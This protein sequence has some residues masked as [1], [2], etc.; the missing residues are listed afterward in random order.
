[1]RA[2]WWPLA[3]ALKALIS[4]SRRSAR[5]ASASA[6]VNR[7]SLI[8]GPLDQDGAGVEQ[9]EALTLRVL[10]GLGPGLGDDHGDVAAGRGRVGQPGGQQRG[11]HAPAPVRGHG[12]RAGELRD[13]LGYPHGGPADDDPVAQRGVADAAGRDRVV[14]GLDDRLARELLVP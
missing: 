10:L 2:S 4:W 11:L 6:T 1:M 14:L 7:A 5:S 9:V 13:A 8:T 12:R 3:A